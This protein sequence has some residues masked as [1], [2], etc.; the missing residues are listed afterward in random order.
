MERL[1]SRALPVDGKTELFRSSTLS[2]LC[3]RVTIPLSGITEVLTLGSKEFAD[4]GVQN[5][6]GRI[7]KLRGHQAR[8][9]S[10]TLMKKMKI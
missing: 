10:L 5:I 1:E 6:L 3:L 7:P 9:Q 4:H 2:S 8:N